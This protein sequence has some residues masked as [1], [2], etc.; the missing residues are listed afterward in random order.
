MAA[1]GGL[2]R[3]VG[4]PWRCQG[5]GLGPGLAR[6]RQNGLDCTPVRAGALFYWDPGIVEGGFVA[7]GPYSIPVKHKT[8]SNKTRKADCH[9]T[10]GPVRTAL[11]LRSL[12]APS[13]EGPADIY[14]ACMISIYVYVY[15]VVIHRR[16]V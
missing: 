14:Y 4:G 1:G 2:G 12:V 7:F 10:E 16:N 8:I 13:K 11:L 3:H 6:G 5:L 15:R 9:N